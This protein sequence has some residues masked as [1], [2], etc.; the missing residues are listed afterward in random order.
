MDGPPRKRSGDLSQKIAQGQR[1]GNPDRRPQSEDQLHDGQSTGQ[2]VEKGSQKFGDLYESVSPST[3][4]PF[5]SM[6]S[7]EKLGASGFW[8]ESWGCAPARRILGG[9][10]RMSKGLNAVASARLAC[11]HRLPGNQRFRAGFAAYGI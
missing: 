3:V 2:R 4:S 10:A 7:S 6:E 1:Q 9:M 11:R 8:V 5:W